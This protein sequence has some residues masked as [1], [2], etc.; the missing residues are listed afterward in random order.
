MPARQAIDMIQNQYMEMS[1][2]ERK[3]YWLERDLKTFNREKGDGSCEI[4]N[5]KGLIAFIDGDCVRCKPCKC[6]IREINELRLKKSGLKDLLDIYTFDNFKVEEEW[7]KRLK[8]SAIEFLK[9]PKGWFFVGGQVGCGKTHICT[10]I[11]G[12][13]LKRGFESRYIVW[14]NEVTK[15]K[16]NKNDEDAYNRLISPLEIAKVLYIDDFL[17]VGGN[18][19]T[20]TASDIRTAFEILNYRYNNRKDLIT[21]IS[22]EKTIDNIID[23]DEAL[24]SRINEMSKKFRSIIK[25]EKSRNYRLKQK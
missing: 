6:R 10:A 4:C 16:A 20:P 13:L 21:I 24:G 15:L 5:G 2:E 7:Q 17:K 11:V 18:S 22:S 3:R 25:Y 19:D 1:T 23:C 14:T 8:E 9:E 12:E